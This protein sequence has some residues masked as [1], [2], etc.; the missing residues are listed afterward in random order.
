LRGFVLALALLVASCGQDTQTAETP[1]AVVENTLHRGNYAEPESLDPAL[2]DVAP[3]L[4]IVADLMIGLI[5]DNA[6]GE[7][8]PGAAE[9]WETSADGLV[10][11]FHLRP[12]QWSDGMPVTA[13]DFV[14]AWRRA[15]LPETASEYASILYVFKNAKPINEGKMP[16]ESLGARAV[17]ADTIELT[18]EHP[19]PYLQELLSHVT[20]YPVPRHLVEAKGRE[21]AR[22]GSYVGNGA[23]TL[24]EWL[25]SDHITLT[26][27]PR[28]YDAA[29]VRIE[30]VVYYPTEDYDA[31]LR[32]FR[33]G[34][35]DLHERLPPQQIDWLRANLPDT[36]RMVPQLRI[37]YVVFN[38]TRAP[39]GDVRVR[40]AIS[41]ASDRENLSERIRRLGEPPAYS[42]VPRAI[43]NYPDGPELPFK[44]QPY[45]ER[46][47]RAQE[48][49][50]AAGYGP[51]RRFATTLNLRS[52]TAAERAEGAAL[53]QMWRAI[54]IDVEIV[55]SDNAVF[56]NALR[57]GDFAIAKA[58]WG[59][60]FNDARNFLFLLMGDSGP[61]LNYGRYANA[62]FDALMRRSDQEADGAARAAI[63]A[64]AETIALRDSAWAPLYFW[65]TNDLVHT[66]VKGWVSNA[67]DENRTRWLSIER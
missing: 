1:A 28:F 27:N 43:A 54:Y 33:A 18:L 42:I 20:S 57:T 26:K 56:Y 3:E 4:N 63:M 66:H 13:E 24:L 17:D 19:V 32:R 23:Y 64:E 29:N 45:A 60:D 65:V 61:G 67:M 22:P 50:R 48:L 7:N 10:W 41:L 25:P 16:P 9:R 38:Q 15:L 11:T 52:N 47:A 14:Y 59:A 34:E 40:E 44:A 46:L 6:A 5:G 39:F 58:S 31:A 62:E 53:Q 36:L 51:Q 37:E 30:R 49:M 55:P 8:M 12:H 2:A 35:L 21:W